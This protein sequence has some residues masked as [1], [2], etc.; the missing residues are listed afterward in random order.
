M[1]KKDTKEWQDFIHNLKLS[2]SKSNR[3]VMCTHCWE[4]LNYEVVRVHKVQYPTHTINFKTSRHYASEEKFI[5]LSQLHNR[6]IYDK[7]EDSEYYENP[8]KSQHG[9]GC[10]KRRFKRIRNISLPSSIPSTDH[11]KQLNQIQQDTTH[12]SSKAFKLLL[13]Q[14]T[15]LFKYPQ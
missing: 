10:Q 1:I 7:T 11:Q 14:M 6:I 12:Q 13:L 8:Y 5:K 9:R 15:Q 4:L 3:D 2:K